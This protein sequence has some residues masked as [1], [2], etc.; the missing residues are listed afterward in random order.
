LT[1][2]WFTRHEGASRPPRSARPAPGQSCEDPVTESRI[3]AWPAFAAAAWALV[4]GAVHAAWALGWRAG[5][6]PGQ[7][8]NADASPW[9]AVYAL[10]VVVVCG[11]AI[12][13]AWNL[14]RPRPPRRERTARILGAAAWVGTGVLVLR[15]GGS[16]VP[17]LQSLLDGR[18][19]L[20][21]LPWEPWFWLGAALFGASTWRYHRQR[22]AARAPG[23][24]PGA[25]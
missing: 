14:A 12:L 22:R 7:A 4:F 10:V 24:A 19:L 17:A 9:F 6:T 21:I 18:S 2:H 3:S 5:L 23:T 8:R 15:A 16:V 1:F 13:V 11:V 25:S 20:W